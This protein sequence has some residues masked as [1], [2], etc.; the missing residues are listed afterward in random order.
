MLIMTGAI[1]PYV[2]LKPVEELGATAI[3]LLCCTV[4]ANLS[5]GFRLASALA[6]VAAPGWDE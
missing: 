5:P 2:K 6:P 3:I 4:S 1:V